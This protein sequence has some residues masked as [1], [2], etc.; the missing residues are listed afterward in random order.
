MVHWEA[1]EQMSCLAV[2]QFVDATRQIFGNY[3]APKVMAQ[4]KGDSIGLVVIKG[5][6]LIVPSPRHYF[7]RKAAFE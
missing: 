6:R 1:P 2:K 7:P 4:T 5:W 3:R